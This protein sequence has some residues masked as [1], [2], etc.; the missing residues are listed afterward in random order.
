[1]DSVLKDLMH[2]CTSRG[3]DLSPTSEWNEQEK[4]NNIKFVLREYCQEKT[5]QLANPLI[6]QLCLNV[7]MYLGGD[8]CKASL[9]VKE[10]CTRVPWDKEKLKWP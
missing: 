8:E 3:M 5:I 10:Y 6:K 9:A 2:I 1:M 4:Y 7:A